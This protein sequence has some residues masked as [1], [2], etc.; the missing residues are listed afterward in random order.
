MIRTQSAPG[1]MPELRASNG[2][3]DDGASGRIVA[4]DI[5]PI[6]GEFEARAF[7]QR[8][9]IALPLPHEPLPTDQR[10]PLKFPRQRAVEQR[11]RI[12]HTAPP[13]ASLR[14][15]PSRA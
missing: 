10:Q 11:L 6:V 1:A 7:S 14:S 4:F 8:A 2:T 5:V 3:A 15:L 12:T 9:P 13:S